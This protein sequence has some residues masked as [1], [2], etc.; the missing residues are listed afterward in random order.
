MS[1]ILEAN[2]TPA[3]AGGEK[4]H[5]VLV[6]VSIVF[7]DKASGGWQR[8]TEEFVVQSTTCILPQVRWSGLDLGKI[9][10]RKYDVCK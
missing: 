1:F 6:D 4:N 5:F 3:F 2:E 8:C 7:Q 9:Q 10:R